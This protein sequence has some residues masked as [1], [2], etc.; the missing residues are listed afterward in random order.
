[1]SFRQDLSGYGE[2]AEGLWD[3]FQR[4]NSDTQSGGIVGIFRQGS[5]EE[6]RKVTVNYLNPVAN[7]KVT[8]APG[9]IKIITATGKKLAEEGFT[10]KFDKPFEGALYE[11]SK[12]K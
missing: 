8:R 6:Q 3:G 4:I 2:P 9:D 10:V 5:A 1:M 12:I 11:I 7:Y